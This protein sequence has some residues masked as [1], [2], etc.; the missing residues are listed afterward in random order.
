MLVLAY[1]KFKE[2]IRVVDFSKNP[3]IRKACSF[4]LHIVSANIGKKGHFLKMWVCFV[5]RLNWKSRG[6]SIVP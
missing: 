2:N 3:Q 5:S 4:N 1:Y 6:V